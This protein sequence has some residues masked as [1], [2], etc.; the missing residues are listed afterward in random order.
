MRFVIDI[1]INI[2]KSAI[3]GQNI[4]CVFEIITAFGLIER[5]CWTEELTCAGIEDNARPAL[6]SDQRLGPIS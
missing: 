4:Y 2:L 5:I 6:A 3:S 1:A